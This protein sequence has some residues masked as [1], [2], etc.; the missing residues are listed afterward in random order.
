MLFTSFLAFLSLGL[1]AGILSGLM[2]IGG[3][4]VMVPLLIFLFNYSQKTANGISLVAMLLPVG[5]LAVWQYYRDGHIQITPHIQGGLIIGAGIF[6]GAWVGARLASIIPAPIAS[7]IFAILL[8]V[9]A[10]KLWF[11]S[12]QGK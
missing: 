4:L 9:G 10:I 7:K 5:I 3:G 12:N 1:F 11:Y 8:I 2:G 6:F